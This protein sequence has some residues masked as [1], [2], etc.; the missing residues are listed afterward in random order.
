MEPKV[1]TSYCKSAL[2]LIS[3]RVSRDTMT[4]FDFICQA[5]KAKEPQPSQVALTVRLHFIK[6]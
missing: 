3:T 1:Y 4:L 6:D 2:D 5:L